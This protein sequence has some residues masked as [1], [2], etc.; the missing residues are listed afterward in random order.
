MVLILADIVLATATGV[1]Q[2]MAGV[3]LWGLYMGLTHGVLAA[4]VTDNSPVHL[5]GTAFGIFNFLSGIALLLASVI[6]GWLWDQ[7]GAPATFYT[8]AGFAC[9]ALIGLMTIGTQK[10]TSQERDSAE[11]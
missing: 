2:V 10:K 4:L 1:W 6:A 7:Y 8:G 3:V 5:R 9:V 11:P